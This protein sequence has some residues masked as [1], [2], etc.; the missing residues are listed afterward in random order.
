MLVFA[1]VVVV[2]YYSQLICFC[3]YAVCMPRCMGECVCIFSPPD[4]FYAFVCVFVAEALSF[5][6]IQLLRLLHYR[7]YFSVRFLSYC[8]C[9]R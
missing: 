6:F 4:L 8:A 2:R 9:N 1:V 7:V 5:G 3:M